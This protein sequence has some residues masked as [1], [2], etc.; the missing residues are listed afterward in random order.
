MRRLP[1]RTS[2][3]RMCVGPI[4]RVERHSVR[5]RRG[6]RTLLH[7]AFDRLDI[8]FDSTF[9]PRRV[10]AQHGRDAVSVLLGDP[11]QIFPNHQIPTH[12][13]VACAVRLSIAQLDGG[14]QRLPPPLVGMIQPS[15]RLSCG[16]E[17]HV[18]VLDPSR[19]FEF[20][21]KLQLTFQYRQSSRAQEHA[22][23]FTRF[24]TVPVNARDA[25]L[26]DAD[27]SL[28]EIDVGEHECDLLGRS[29][30]GEEPEL[31]VVSLGFTPIP[32]DRGNQRFRVLD[33]EG[34]DLR[35]VLLL[36]SNG[37][38]AKRGVVMLVQDF[39]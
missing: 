32:M 18:V 37:S 9:G 4:R 17:E 8:R 39:V 34:I 23:V 36:Q 33:V 5:R 2:T 7:R 31:I 1:S 14:P 26:V 35:P 38:K 19:V 24:C 29:H 16:L 11:Q 28:L 3:R 6:R 12:R 13:G 30:A 21:S 27:G 22:P 15:D 10:N 25:C 20:G